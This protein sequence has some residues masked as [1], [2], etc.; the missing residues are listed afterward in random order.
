MM[1]NYSPLAYWSSAVTSNRS[2]TSFSTKPGSSG[3]R[4]PA[5]VSDT[6]L[7]SPC[8]SQ[9]APPSLLLTPCLWLNDSSCQ[10][11]NPAYIPPPSS[12]SLYSDWMLPD[13]LSW[14][15]GC[16]PEQR[17]CV[18]CGMQSAPLWRRDAAGRL[19]CNTCGLRQ[20]ANNTPLLR[21]KRRAYDVLFQSR[22]QRKGTQCVNCLTERTTL[23]RRNSAGEAVC[24]ACGLYYR[25]HRVNRPLALKKDGI[26]TRKRKVVTKNKRKTD[27]SDT[28]LPKRVKPNDA[29]AANSSVVGF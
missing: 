23:W 28:K 9:E 22:I 21:P 8:T 13:S 10:S 18:S 11:P 14:G 25:L 26:Q 2:E 3:V 24:N 29:T 17:E 4:E 15:Q 27:Q 20:E 5:V 16:G 19:L 1:S 6:F 7:Q 12:S